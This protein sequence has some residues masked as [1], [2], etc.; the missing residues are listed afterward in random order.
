MATPSIC[1]NNL[2]LC[3]II[4]VVAIRI[5]FTKMPLLQGSCTFGFS[6]EL[7]VSTINRIVSNNFGKVEILFSQVI[8]INSKTKD[9]LGIYLQ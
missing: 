1:W 5:S 8:A 4:S 7:I 6:S 3:K 9:T 2:S